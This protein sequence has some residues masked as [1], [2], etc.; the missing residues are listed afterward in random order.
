MGYNTGEKNIR[1]TKK[2]LEEEKK[3]KGRK[4]SKVAQRNK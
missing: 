2:D 4:S 1:K 3:R